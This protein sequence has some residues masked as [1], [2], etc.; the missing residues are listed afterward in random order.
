MLAQLSLVDFLKQTASNE[1]VPGGGSIAAMSGATAA[2]L[3][4]MVASLT[5]GRKKYEAVEAEMLEV[6]QK[7]AAVREKLLKDIDR[8]AASFNHVMEAMK[9]P[10]ETE[11]EKQVRSK[12][13]EAATKEAALVPLEVAKTTLEFMPLIEQVVTKGNQNAVTDGAVAAMM[14]RTAVKAALYNVKINLLGLKDEA[15]VAEL[16]PQIEAIE[17]EV[18]AME[19]KILGQVKL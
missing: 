16:T 3:G 2:A 15:F 14:A 5:I 11:E 9:L 10:K 7:A 1:P 17:A 4:E 12:A 19:Q 18:E 13:I 6:Q 8:D